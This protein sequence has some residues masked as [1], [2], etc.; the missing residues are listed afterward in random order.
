MGSSALF[1]SLYLLSSDEESDHLAESVFQAY[2]DKH[3]GGGAEIR[4][5][6]SIISQAHGYRIG[7]LLVY[8]GNDTADAFFRNGAVAAVSSKIEP[9]PPQQKGFHQHHHRPLNEN[10]GDG[11]EHHVNSHGGG[12]GGR[13]EDDDVSH[14]TGDE[15]LLSRGSDDDDDDDDDEG[16]DDQFHL[17]EEAVTQLTKKYNELETEKEKA[18]VLNMELQ[19]KCSSILARIGRDIQSRNGPPGGGG[20]GGGGGDQGQENTGGAGDGFN[21]SNN[22]N[23]S[24]S[25]DNNAAEKENHFYETLSSISDGRSK[26]LKQQTE[27][28]QLAYDL[29]SRLDEKEYK[30]EEIS[31]SL[32]E[33]KREILTKA[34]NSRTAQGLSKRLIKQFE[35]NEKKKDSELE[36]V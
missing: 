34:E 22:N 17:D 3:L 4:L 29:Q 21:N 7:L 11:P 24:N 10:Q 5:A 30:A 26:L 16:E 19:K 23:N 25:L 15:D 31:E 27:Y 6:P 18:L 32:N 12:G 9:A 2:V 28:E 33:F 1:S 13:T 20:G 8:K 36:K 14:M 35:Y